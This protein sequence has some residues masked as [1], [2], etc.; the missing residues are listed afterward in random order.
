EVDTDGFAFAKTITVDNSTAALKGIAKALIDAGKTSD[1][2]GFDAFAKSVAGAKVTD[3]IKEVAEMYAKAKKAMIVFQQNN[4]SV[5]AATLIADI[6]L[7]SG[8]ISSPRNG[9]LQVKAKNNSQGLVDMGIKA[10]AEAMEGVK[11]LLCFGE[12]P[13]VDLSG[14][15]FLMVSDTH[16]TKTAQKADVILPGTGFAS[17]DGTFTNTERR[18]Q[19]VQ[20]AVDE[21]VFYNNWEIAKEIAHVYEVEFDFE[22]TY[23]ISREMD[24]T[25]PRYKYAEVGEIFGGVLTPAEPK[26]VAVDDAK[27]VDTLKCTDNLMNTI[28]ARLPKRAKLF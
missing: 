25:L 12:D 4:V 3:E 2:E 10:G 15:E 27:L 13:D 19:P 22:D 8:H 26:F 1:A 6:A 14:L 11:A 17:T 28:V 5:E 16:L 24:D 7:V 18:L 20:A 23:D 21:E 9:I